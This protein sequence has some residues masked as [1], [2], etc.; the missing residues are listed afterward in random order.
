MDTQTRKALQAII[1]HQITES[2]YSIERKDLWKLYHL[3]ESLE[4]ENAKLLDGSTMSFFKM[5]TP[6]L[7][8]LGMLAL[9]F[10]AA[11]LVDRIL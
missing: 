4:G 10:I 6:H 9:G 2:M 7:P 5:F 1:Q 3:M 8:V 11:G